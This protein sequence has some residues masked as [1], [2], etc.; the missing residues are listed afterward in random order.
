MKTC[1]TCK[2][3]KTLAS[4]N[5]CKTY[6][7]GLSRQCRDCSKI[8]AKKCREREKAG[9]EPR[10]RRGSDGLVSGVMWRVDMM[11]DDNDDSMFGEDGF[12]PGGSWG[13]L[14]SGDYY[15]AP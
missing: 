13:E 2:K 4:F 7:D 15:S 10:A 1:C 5:K 12:Y 6:D 8:S 14:Y 9:I 3:E 11:Y